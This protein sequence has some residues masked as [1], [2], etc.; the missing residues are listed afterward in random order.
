MALTRK[1]L[2]AMGIE[3]NKIDEIINAHTEVTDALKSE[4]DGLKDKAEKLD[5]VQKDLDKANEKIK[6]L[7]SDNSEDTWKAKYEQAVKDKETAEQN[8]KDYKTDIDNKEK[9]SKKTEAYKN[10][11]KESGVSEKR[12][13]TILKVT[14]IAGIEVDK[15]GNFKDSEELKKNIQSEWADFIT[16][17]GLQGTN[18]PKPPAGA[19]NGGGTGAS[20]ATSYAQKY[21]ADRY[22]IAKED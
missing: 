15:E 4:R 7:E 8:L 5:T 2:S 22:G 10:L 19:G 21:Y 9:L 11:L 1:L 13:D 16:T 20:Y 6:E 14:D 3:D 18:T 12:I 17:E